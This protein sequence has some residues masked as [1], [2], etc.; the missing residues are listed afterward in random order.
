[1]LWEMIRY[2]LEGEESVRYNGVNTRGDN[3]HVN[4]R[5]GKSC[6]MLHPPS[7]IVCLPETPNSGWY[8]LHRVHSFQISWTECNS[9]QNLISPCVFT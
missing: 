1:M 9:S 7:F 3:V 8:F 4:R 5:V 6:E 2:E